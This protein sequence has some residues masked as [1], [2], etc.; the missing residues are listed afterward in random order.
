MFYP[1]K[2][3]R[4]NLYSLRIN[5]ARKL[6]VRDKYIS[7]LNSGRTRNRIQ[8]TIMDLRN[9][10]TETKNEENVHRTRSLSLHVR[11]FDWAVFNV[12]LFYLYSCYAMEQ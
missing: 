7:T 5:R 8:Q 11:N 4:S 6:I 1:I 10:E 9:A 2:I 3:T 12:C